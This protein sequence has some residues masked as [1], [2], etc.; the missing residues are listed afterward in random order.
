MKYRHKDVIVPGEG[1]RLNAFR[2]LVNND[3]WVCRSWFAQGLHNLE[4][5]A[6]SM[7]VRQEDGNVVLTFDVTSKAPNAAH[8]VGN[9]SSPTCVI[10]EEQD[11][12]NVMAFTSHVTWTVAR[13]GSITLSSKITSDKPEQVLGRLGYIMQVPASLA[14]LTYYG[15]GPIENYSDR[16]TCAFV[17]TYSGTVAEEVGNYTKP[18]DMANHEQVRWASLTGKRG[19]GVLFEAALNSLKSSDSGLPV[20]SVS[21]L[22][23]SAVDMVQAAHQ[24]EL[25]EPGDT[26]LCLD[27][28][29]TGLGG[30]SCGP[31]PLDED[32]VHPEADFGFVIRMKR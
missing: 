2:A 1:P 4:H 8:I 26:W 18:Q 22:P 10:E 32:R 24:Y 14:D 27:A 16:Y 11:N 3:G 20:M 19:K 13:D 25:P 29:D 15:R 6:S 23:Y 9:H 21:A 17:G 7:T 30:A 12:H 28:A 31:A 5:S